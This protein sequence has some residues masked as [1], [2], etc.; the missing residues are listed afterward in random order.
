MSEPATSSSSLRRTTWLVAVLACLVVIAAAVLGYPR[1][2][3][4]VWILRNVDTSVRNRYLAIQEK[5]DAGGAWGTDEEAC[6]IA[7]VCIASVREPPACEACVVELVRAGDGTVAKVLIY[8]RQADRSAI[9]DAA[10]YWDPAQSGLVGSDA[11]TFDVRNVELTT[12]L[13]E[14]GRLVV[15]HRHTID[16]WWKKPGGSGMDASEKGLSASVK[17]MNDF[18]RLGSPDP[19]FLSADVASIDSR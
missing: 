9:L 8:V 13:R 17:M 15:L 12:E 10:R 18:H 16:R 14:N 11:D 3:R 1:I 19:V 4:H 7:R 2:A 5:L 6:R